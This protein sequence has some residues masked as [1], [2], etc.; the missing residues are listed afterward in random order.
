MRI[1][2][3]VYRGRTLKTLRGL[4][5]RPTSDRLRETLF[6]VLGASIEGSVFIDGYAGSGAVGL[7]AFSRGARQVFLIEENVAAIQFI[8]A[9]LASLGVHNCV[10]VIRASVHKGLR[11]LEERGVLADFC[12][13]DP[14]YAAR[15]ESGRSL[16]WLSRSR[17]MAPDGLIVLQS[18]RKEPP[19]EQVDGWSRTRLLAQGSSALGFYRRKP[20]VSDR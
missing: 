4:K 18:S 13:L 14:P 7:E 11:V 1:I 20:V 16:L 9:N 8:R 12:F 5:L 19:E 15:R 2:A 17:L 10:D 3:G 6:D